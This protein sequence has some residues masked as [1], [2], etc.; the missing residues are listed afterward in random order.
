MVT[1]RSPAMGVGSNAHTL[2]VS[3][4]V[5]RRYARAALMPA[6]KNIAPT[7]LRTNMYTHWWVVMV[8]VAGLDGLA[9]MMYEVDGI[10]RPVSIYQ[11]D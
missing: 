2:S 7:P 11:V 8:S 3:V 6:F 9:P 5:L 4:F 1:P 10:V